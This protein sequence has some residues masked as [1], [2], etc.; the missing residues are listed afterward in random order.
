MIIRDDA[1]ANQA[2]RH[3]APCASR[4]QIRAETDAPSAGHGEKI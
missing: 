2:N 3:P 1:I 4:D